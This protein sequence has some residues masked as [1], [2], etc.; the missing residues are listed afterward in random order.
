[1]VRKGLNKMDYTKQIFD[2]LGVEPEEEFELVST[3]QYIDCSLERFK[4]DKLLRVF[5]FDDIDNQ[6]WIQTNMS[7]NDI[8]LGIFKIVKIPRSTENGIDKI[9]LKEN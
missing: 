8:L 6:G 1:M 5:G 7:L 9:E 4:I 2:M 3:S